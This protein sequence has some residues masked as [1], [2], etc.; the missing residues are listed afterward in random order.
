[1]SQA[2]ESSPIRECKTK[3]NRISKEFFEK[4]SQ[5]YERSPIRECKAKANRISKNFLKRC[6][7]SMNAPL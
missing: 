2:Y 6:R 3:A 7:K 4:M 5:V 1:M